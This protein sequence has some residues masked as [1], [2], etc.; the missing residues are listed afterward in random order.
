LA[1][2]LIAHPARKSEQPGQFGFEHRI[3]V[4]LTGKFGPKGAARLSDK[5]GAIDGKAN[6]RR[7][8]LSVEIDPPEMAGWTPAKHVASGTPCGSLAPT[9]GPVQPPPIR[10]RGKVR[11]VNAGSSNRW[12]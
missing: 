2:P 11:H 6:R 8:Y 3:A 5:S 4:D 12:F 10:V 9:T 1:A 7:R